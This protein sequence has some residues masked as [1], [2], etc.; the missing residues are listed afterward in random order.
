M[1]YLVIDADQ[2]IVS[3]GMVATQTAAEHARRDEQ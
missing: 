2:A 3:G 1:P